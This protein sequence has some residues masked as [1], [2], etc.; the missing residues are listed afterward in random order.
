MIVNCAGVTIITRGLILS[1]LQG[2]FASLTQCDLTRR[3]LRKERAT[4]LVLDAL[5][6]GC[7]R[8]RPVCL[9]IDRFA[10]LNVNRRNVNRCAKVGQIGK[11]DWLRKS[12]LAP[13]D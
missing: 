13:K 11:I 4:V 2:T 6:L 5:A 9:L 1:R 3:R 12:R 10:G 7:V 8:V